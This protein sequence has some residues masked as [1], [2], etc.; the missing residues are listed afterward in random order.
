MLESLQSLIP[1][2]LIFALLAVFGKSVYS[3]LQKV[4]LDTNTNN[5]SPYRIGYI[6]SIYG[7]LF[8]GPVGLWYVLVH[9]VTMSAGALAFLA[10]LGLFEVVA[11]SV[12]MSSL[13]ETDLGIASALK[14]LSP[15]L[16]ALLE[17]VLLGTDLDHRVVLA[18]F[19]TGIGAYTVLLNSKD[20]LAPF[21]RILDDRGVALALLATLFYALLAITSRVG[22]TTFSPYVFGASVYTTMVVGFAVAHYQTAGRAAFLSTS[23]AA[24]TPRYVPLGFAAAFRSLTVWIAYSLT[25]ATHVASITT[26]VVVIDIIAG[27]ALLEEERIGQRLV[28]ASLI[29]TGVVIITML[30]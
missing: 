27:G 21:K 25:A 5:E 22:A 7:T 15:A 30:S 9:D 17:P 6:S 1:L 12:F 11:L 16:V 8:V 2:W 26:L 24:F 10:G 29:V 20:V 28:G 3:Y 18:A 13:A 14:K 4:F 23:R 19:L